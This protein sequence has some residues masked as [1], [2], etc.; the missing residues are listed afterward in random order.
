MTIR[1]ALL[2]DVEA[3]YE[4]YESARAFMKKNGNP[5][6]WGGNYPARDNIVEGIKS[7]VS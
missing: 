1:P 5:T 2:A 4:I 7:G 6:Q 3:A